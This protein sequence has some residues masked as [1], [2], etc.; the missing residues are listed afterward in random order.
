[1]VA[2]GYIVSAKTDTALLCCSESADTRGGR[3]ARSRLGSRNARAF[4]IL[5]RLEFRPSR[6]TVWQ[7]DVGLGEP[8]GFNPA[9]NRARGLA[10]VTL[11]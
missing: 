11:C 10:A 4:M 6:L 9:V 1:M 2:S 7:P 3:S 5:Q 8:S